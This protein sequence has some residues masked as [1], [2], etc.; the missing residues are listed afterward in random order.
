MGYTSFPWSFY[1]ADTISIFSLAAEKFAL[2]CGSFQGR[3]HG[4]VFFGAQHGQIGQGRGNPAGVPDDARPVHLQQKRAQAEAAADSQCG[5]RR[6]R[7]HV[8]ARGNEAARAGLVSHADDGGELPEGNRLPRRVL[9][10]GEITVY[11]GEAPAGTF[12]PQEPRRQH[13][14]IRREILEKLFRRHYARR[15]DE[16]QNPRDVR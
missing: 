2:L 5:T 3:D 15:A 11:Q 4:Q 1:G 9:G 7:P 6:R 14:E 13:G 8:R 16:G 12:N 10:L